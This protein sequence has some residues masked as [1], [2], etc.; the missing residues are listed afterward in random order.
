[1]Q[2][3]SIDA[4]EARSDGSL[5]G[6]GELP[7]YGEVLKGVLDSD[8]TF[9]VRGD[10]AEQCWRIIEPVRKAWEAGSVPL[11]EYAAG[12]GGPAGWPDDE[13]PNG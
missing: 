9:S 11:D 3:Q 12:S 8:P 1:M 13:Q 2:T 10:A 5:P 6:A 7:E 4:V